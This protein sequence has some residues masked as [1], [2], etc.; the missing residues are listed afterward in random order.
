MKLTLLSGSFSAKEMEKIITDMIKVKIKYHEDKIQATDDMET[1]KMRENRIIKLQNDLKSAR[2][3]LQ[4]APTM[5]Q[6]AAEI[7]IAK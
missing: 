3:Y 7:T 4:N 5:I 2:E 6:A 1:I